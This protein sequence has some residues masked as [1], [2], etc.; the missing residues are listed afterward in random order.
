MSV[1]PAQSPPTLG[2]LLRG[3]RSREGWTLKEM[4][5]RI[6][7]PVSTLSKIEHDRLTLTYDK[8]Q[9]LGQRL[10]MRMSELFAEGEEDT[11]QPVTARRSLGDITRSVRVETPNYDYHYL[12]TELRRKRMVPVLTTIRA[13]SSEQFGELVRHSGEEFLYV[14]SG[15]VVVHTEFYDPVTLEPGQALYID[16]SMGHAYLAAGD[17]EKAE[18]LAVM[19]SAEEELM[20]SL[21][22]I[23]EEQRLGTGAVNENGPAD[24]KPRRGKAG[25]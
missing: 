11:A 22:S 14:L 15:R 21:L 1:P 5:A 20:Q 23:H 24:A 19:S 10:G 8:L 25:R 13:H 3:L 12:C 9:Q 7:I 18:V 2:A 16:S 4:S 17:C 6:G